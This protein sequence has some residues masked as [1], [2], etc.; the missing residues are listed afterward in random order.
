MANEPI[1]CS[2]CNVAAHVILEGDIPQRVVC[3]RCG[4][5]EDYARVKQ[6]I[7]HQAAAYAA[8]EIGKALKGLARGNKGVSY[9]PG[10]IRSQRSKFR[11]DFP[12]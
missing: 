1:K 9:K 6:S 5:S 12:R 10:R 7:G 3:P 4:T 8:D 2:S 11:V